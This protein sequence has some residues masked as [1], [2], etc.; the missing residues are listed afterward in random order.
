MSE[1]GSILQVVCIPSSVERICE[2]CFA[3]CN[4]LSTITFKSD[5]KLSCIERSAFEYCSLV[6]SICIPSSVEK[7]SESC[8]Q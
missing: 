1:K 2:C 7:I 3:E 4:S 6:L 8:R 5:S